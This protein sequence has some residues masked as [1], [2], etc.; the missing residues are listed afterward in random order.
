MKQFA[1]LYAALDE[2]TKTNEKLAALRD[3]FAAAPP[4]DAA[5]AIYFLT[6]RRIKRLIA[7]PKLRV[8]LCA[9]A[10]VPQWLFDESY[11]AVGD[12]GETMTLL[13]PAEGEG[14]D[15]PLAAWV[16]DRILPLRD[17]PD[18]A[19]FRNLSQYWLELD[20]RQRF[21]F[22]KLITGEFRVGVSQRLVIRA[23]AEVSGLDA[24]TI[25]H[26]LMGHWEPTASFFEQLVGPDTADADFSRPYPF[27]LA[28]PLELD[29]S[30]LGAVDA[31]QAEWKWDGIRAQLVRRSGGTFLWSRGEELVTERYP[32]IAAAGELLPDGL[33]L[34]GEILA[35]QD[36][37]VLPFAK[38]QQR[39]G[40]T[41]LTRRILETI[42]V[43]YLVFDLLEY[44]GLDVR[45]QPLGWRRTT[46]E[47]VLSS[48][49]SLSRLRPSPI[50]NASSWEELAG[51]RTQS[52]QYHTEGLMLK[53]QGSPYRVGRVRGDWWKWKIEPY[54]VDA[55]LIYAQR[56]SG[57]R[58][59]LYTDYTFAVWHNETLVPFAK[60]YSGLTDEEIREVDRFVRQH[61]LEKF[62]PVRSVQP[63][64]VFELGFEN[65]QRSTRHKSGVA[66]RF[67]RILRWRRDK[68]PADADTLESLQA[69]LRVP[70]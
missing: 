62:G 28:H 12:F 68:K 59:S 10:D 60:A 39:I 5:W 49:P 66:V 53:R 33:V 48:I 69:L 17:A 34:D 42:P 25:A 11:E 46:L 41:K 27:Y 54:T 13:L 45:E 32:E 4:A 16:T 36:D 20:E 63:E 2:T 47:D 24:A 14:T 52:R 15:I 26:R 6:G 22:N 1:E 56:G 18:T 35:M 21:V 40:R 67:P 37:Q 57:K 70:H 30:T 44:E 29:P 3:Y 9:L 8:W 64:L 43:G 51:L 65:I 38:L 19:Q 31:W 7:T 50:V 55:V 61:T 23:L 58:A